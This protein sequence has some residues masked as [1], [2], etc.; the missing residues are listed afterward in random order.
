MYLP[1]ELY[2]LM[3]FTYAIA[4]LSV[5]Y[6]FG[7]PHGYTLG[8]ILLVSALLV[9]MMRRDYRAGNGNRRKTEQ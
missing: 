9:W 8:G 4:G 2:E 6:H 3:P 7:A 5:P 1:D